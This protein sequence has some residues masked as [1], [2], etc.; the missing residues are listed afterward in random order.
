[1]VE[2][3]KLCMVQLRGVRVTIFENFRLCFG[4]KEGIDGTF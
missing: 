3:R 4:Q 1:M 2:L